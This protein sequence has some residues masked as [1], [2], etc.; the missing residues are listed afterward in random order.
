MSQNESVNG[1][2][3]TPVDPDFDP[4]ADL[5][6]VLDLSILESDRYE[7]RSQPQPHG[8]VFGGQVLA[9]SLIAAGLTVRD[10]D[11]VDERPR[12]VHSMHAYFLRAGDAERPITF[13][14]ERLRDGRSFSARR[15]LALQYDRPILAMS[16]SFQTLDE[17]ISHQDAM[18]QVAPPEE[19]PSVAELLHGVADGPAKKWAERRAIDIRHVE[20][21]M[22]LEPAAERA[23]RQN[24]WIRATGD[25]P[26]DPL[27]NAAVLAYASDYTLLEA[28]LR[29]HGISWS[30]PRLRPASLD[31]SMWFHRPARADDWILYSQASPSAQ[32]GRGLGIGRMFARDGTLVASVAQEGMLR[33]RGS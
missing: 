22:Y 12:D 21:S 20:G 27:F 29:H 8:R 3:R 24:V 1:A 18:P 6:D 15:V 17:G 2:R 19:L 33:L 4:F 14:V 26:K 25:L 9:Q 23:T 11:D 31:H 13:E 10:L 7:G 5:L 16:A 32:G 30:D 28:V